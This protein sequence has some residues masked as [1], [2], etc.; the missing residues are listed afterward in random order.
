MPDWSRSRRYPLGM[1]RMLSL[2]R[3]VLSSQVSCNPTLHTGLV[4]TWE[5]FASV[6]HRNPFARS[7]TSTPR[8]FIW[9]YAMARKYSAIRDL[10]AAAYLWMRRGGALVD[11]RLVLRAFGLRERRD[12]KPR[13]FKGDVASAQLVAAKLDAFIIVAGY[14]VPSVVHAVEKGNARLLNLSGKPVDAQ[15]RNTSTL[16]AI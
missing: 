15:I 6:K 1:L 10:K 9:W 16:A 4:R 7:L 8:A 3:T 13:Y 14:P 2:Q 12:F 5:F 11:A